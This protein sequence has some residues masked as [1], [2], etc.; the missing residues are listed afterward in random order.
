MTFLLTF[1][2]FLAIAVWLLVLARVLLS[3]VDPSGRSRVATYIFAFT[4][5]ILAPVRR[6]LPSTGMMD[7]SGFIVLFALS[8]LIRS[9]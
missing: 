1:L 7:W 3:W 8:F 6:V 5:P 4:E 9:L 2:R